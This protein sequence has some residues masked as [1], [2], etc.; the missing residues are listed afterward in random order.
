MIVP[1]KKA[2]IIVQEK[3][4]DFAVGALRGLGVLHV[5]H[6]R[7]PAGRELSLIVEDA[8]LLNAAIGILSGKEFVVKEE[9]GTDE[10]PADWKF[11]ARHIVD[12][13]KRLD[14]LKEY[15]RSLDAL[16]QRWES[17]GD[18]DPEQIHA[19]R[20]RGIYLRLYQIPA[21]DLKKP[22]QDLLIRKFSVV[23]GLM[24]CAV[25]SRD[26]C[27]LAYKELELPKTGLAAMRARLAEDSRMMKLIREEIH[28]QA[29][30]KT[31]L[32][33]ARDALKK[34]QELCE[35]LSGMGESAGLRYLNGYLP[36]DKAHI[37][38]TLAKKE[39]WGFLISDPEEDDLVPTLTRLPRWL[40]I[41]SPVFKAIELVPGYHEL[42]ISFWF[43]I[44][45]S[46]FFGMIIGDAGYGII[47]SALTFIAQLKW[48]KKVSGAGPFVLL[49]LLS[50]CAVIWG[51]LT[52]TFF[53]QEWL[54]GLFGPPVPALRSNK[55]IQELCFFLGALHLS[56]AH[57]WRA[58][59]KLPSLKA[60][61]EAGW[62]LI[63][64]GAFFLARLLILRDVF[65]VFGKWFF[66]GGAALVVLFTSPRKDILKG[67][68][69][70]L[71]DLFL[72]LINNFT[73]IVSYIRLFAVGMATVAV[74]DSFNRM[75]S[76]VG[77]GS[78]VSGGLA[79]LI[80][81]L[82]HSLNILLGPMSILVHGVRLNVLEFCGHLN[83]KWSGFAYKPLGAVK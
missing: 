50:G 70:G 38:S 9:A 42:D 71:G 44:F 26:G 36:A 74:A 27:N 1:M 32:V 67:V 14:Q 16:I 83:I 25:V 13:K 46:V 41:I 5:E 56:I 47:F 72:N 64:W 78:V 79:A 31:A 17:W 7:V 33:N 76:G 57:C 81:L 48:G 10:A 20:Q 66:A 12:L 80:L 73:D 24:N 54:S 29:A 11:T 52:G 60:L 51:F 55:N 6:Q 35:A 43:L 39:R 3:D 2:A 61:S 62:L 82:G 30:Y 77:F 58:L 18:F 63:L 23:G 15:S 69:A 19:L 21:A 28:K 40:K 45:F 37:L 34:E 4:A 75:A 22:P 59:I 8:G 53:G 68:G 65:P 49:Y